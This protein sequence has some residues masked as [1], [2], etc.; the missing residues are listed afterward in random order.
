MGDRSLVEFA[1][2]VEV[3]IWALNSQEGGFNTTCPP[4]EKLPIRIGI[5]VGDVVRAGEDARVTF[6]AA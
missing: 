3:V 4:N 5:H 6:P 1:S 2:A